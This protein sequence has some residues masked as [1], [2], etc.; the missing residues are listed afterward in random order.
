ML[1]SDIDFYFYDKYLIKMKFGG[2]ST[3]Y[4]NIIKQQL[5]DFRIIKDVFYPIHKSNIIC[6]VTLIM[7]KLRKVK[8]FFKKN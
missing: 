1:S 3:T 7:K 4:K 6:F 5:Y 2:M 8:Q